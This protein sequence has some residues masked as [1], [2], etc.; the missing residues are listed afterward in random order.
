[1]R[2]KG[3]YS[4]ER[5]PTCASL[6]SFGGPLASFVFFKL[7]LVDTQRMLF[8]SSLRKLC[9]WEDNLYAAVEVW[10]LEPWSC[11]CW[12]CVLAIRLHPLARRESC[13]ERLSNAD[14]RKDCEFM[15]LA[16]EVPFP[17]NGLTW[18]GVL[19]GPAFSDVTGRGVAMAISL[20]PSTANFN[21]HFPFLPYWCD[22]SFVGHY[23]EAPQ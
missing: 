18:L 8:A 23:S 12:A 22:F 20:F 14:L 19:A 3:G 17:W 21:E 7:E 10:L 9:I 4:A 11:V 6:S 15:A 13:W 1:M 16:P 2:A 5:L